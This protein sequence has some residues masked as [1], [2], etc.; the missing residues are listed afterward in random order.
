MKQI[1]KP[2]DH[3]RLI[4]NFMFIYMNAQPFFILLSVQMTAMIQSVILLT[5]MARCSNVIAAYAAGGATNPKN[6]FMT[7]LPKLCNYILS[8]LKLAFQICPVLF[9]QGKFGKQIRD[10]FYYR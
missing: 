9:V 7:I 6:N 5:G 10:D 2:N 3:N 4:F 8:L 1:R